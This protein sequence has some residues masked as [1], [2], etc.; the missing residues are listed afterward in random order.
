MQACLR[1]PWVARISAIY[2]SPERKATHSAT[3]LANHLRLPLV[4]IP[5]LRENDRSS[6]GYLPPREFEL[7]ADAFFANPHDS[8]RGWERAIDAQAR[9][10][11]AILKISEASHGFP[12]V[13]IVSHGAVGTLLYCHLRRHAISRDYDQPPNGGGNY[14][15]FSMSPPRTHGWWLPIDELVI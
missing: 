7:T 6:T 5:D 3:H 11:S 12:A 9:V 15:S 14:F 1:L 4:E 2:T 13:A 8:V 10:V